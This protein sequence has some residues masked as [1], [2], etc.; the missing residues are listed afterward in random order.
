MMRWWTP[1]YWQKTS[2]LAGQRERLALLLWPFLS[3]RERTE[4]D[5]TPLWLLGRMVRA[6]ENGHVDFPHDPAA[7]WLWDQARADPGTLQ[8]VADL[9]TLRLQLAGDAEAATRPVAALTRQQLKSLR[10]RMDADRLDDGGLGLHTPVLVPLL[11]AFFLI[12]GWLFNSIFFNHF[13]MPV[14]R[15][16]GL[17]DY[18]AA[19]FDGLA[20]SAIALVLSLL[21]QWIARNRIRLQTLQNRLGGLRNL[22]SGLLV[23]V[24]VLPLAAVMN[25]SQDPAEQRLINIFMLCLFMFVVVIQLLVSFSRRPVRDT[26]FLSFVASYLAVIWYSAELRY[27]NLEESVEP[28]E[29]TLVAAPDKPLLS[30]I[31]SGNSLYLFLMNEQQELIA[32][33]IDQVLSVRYIREEPESSP[34]NE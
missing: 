7:Q 27:L 4:D 17:S 30:R 22:G 6:I 13:G 19:S 5:A 10:T 9:R 29:I 31:V 3:E 8:A 2:A 14:G 21:S 20:L 34:E 1:A 25:G 18:L 33:P 26:L 24:I 32:V 23:L 12:S 16:Y 15:Y 28:A 11:S